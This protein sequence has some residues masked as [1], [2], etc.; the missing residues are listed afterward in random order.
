V[1]A[2]I[3]RRADAQAKRLKAEAAEARGELALVTGAKVSLEAHVETE[4]VAQRR[5]L[6]D[7]E[8][9]ELSLRERESKLQ[10]ELSRTTTDF[11]TAKTS[12]QVE[13]TPIA[14]TRLAYACSSPRNSFAAAREPRDWAVGTLGMDGDYARAHT[15]SQDASERSAHSSQLAADP[16]TMRMVGL[17]GP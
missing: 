11:S 2:D 14:S 9:S 8:R 1:T 17:G 3:V 13:S 10:M 16:T 6:E 7:L 5:Q 12:L 4:M 15:P